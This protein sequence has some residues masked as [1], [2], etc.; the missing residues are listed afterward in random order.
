MTRQA[1]FFDRDGVLLELVAGDG[2]LRGARS[3]AEFTVNPQAA[4]VIQDLSERGFLIFIVTNQPDIAR[5]FTTAAQVDEINQS[6]VR[7]LGGVSRIQEVLV[8][9]HDNQHQCPCRKPKPGMILDLAHRW[10]VDLNGSFMVGD[11]GVDIEAGEKA[12]LKTVLLKAGYNLDR[13]ADYRAEDLR[14][15]CDWILS[16]GALPA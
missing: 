9:P 6:L 13:A 5:G 2:G 4:S 12:G 11:R 15:A 8:C 1:V 14:A 3:M 10:Q 16:Q 7:E